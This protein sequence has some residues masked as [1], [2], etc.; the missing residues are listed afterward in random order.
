VWQPDQGDPAG[1]ALNLLLSALPAV[2][3]GVTEGNPLFGTGRMKCP[4]AGTATI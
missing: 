2:K 1:T 3:V 4:V